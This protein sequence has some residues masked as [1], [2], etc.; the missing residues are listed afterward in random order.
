MKKETFYR[1]I[2]DIDD[3]LIQ[4][5]C[6]ACGQNRKRSMFYR[7]AGA[8]ACFCLICGGLFLASERDT[9]RINI[10]P[11]P[12]VSKVVVPADEN[13]KIIP[14]TYQEL[15][16]YYGMEQLP[17][18][19]GELKRTEQSYFVLYQDQNGTVLFDTNI[20]YFS[21]IDKSK[22]V[23]ITIAKAEELPGISG[24]DIKWSEVDGAP[25]VLAVSSKDADH[26]VY[27]AYFKLNNVSVKV[28]S[29]GMSREEFIDV[30]KELLK[31]Y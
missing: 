29:D 9:I 18:T 5:A 28:V 1:E 13:T 10:M 30:I 16:D 20:L 19:F 11:T 8:A 2:G 24:K 22:N 15:L 7:I 31:G 3:D 14:M 4:A 23:S 6:N 26:I 12:A 25:M 27:W 17:D 21:N